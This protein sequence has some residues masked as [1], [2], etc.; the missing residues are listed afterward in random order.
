MPC[1]GV[2]RRVTERLL[3]GTSIASGM[4]ADAGPLQEYLSYGQEFVT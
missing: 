3:Y 2:D 4:G 1:P